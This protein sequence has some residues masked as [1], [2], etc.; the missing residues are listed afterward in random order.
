MHRDAVKPWDKGNPV[1]LFGL[2]PDGKPRLLSCA[3]KARHILVCAPSN[4][5]LDELLGRLLA[6]GLF[7]KC[8]LVSLC[9]FCITADSAQPG[10]HAQR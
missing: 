10:L 8:A 6:A 4:S 9:P 5:A 1:D 3:N 2:Q 7:N